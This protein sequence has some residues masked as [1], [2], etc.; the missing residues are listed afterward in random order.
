M[1]KK[2]KKRVSTPSTV[3]VPSTPLGALFGVLVEPIKP[4]LGDDPVP[5]T[6]TW[7]MRLVAA[8]WNASRNPIELDGLRTLEREIPQLV[9]PAFSDEAAIGALLEEIYHTAR[10]RYP[11]D[12]RYALKLFVERRGPGDFVVEVVPGLPKRKR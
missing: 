12:P 7:A 2:I 6:M 8:A 3:R 9:T 10:V 1:A 11:D 4:L 5:A